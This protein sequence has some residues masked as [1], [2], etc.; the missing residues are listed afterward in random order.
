[1]KLYIL[2]DRRLDKCV[3]NAVIQ[4]LAR[5]SSLPDKSGIKHFMP[6]GVSKMCFD[7]TPEGS[8]I[9]RLIIDVYV[10]IGRKCWLTTSGEEHPEFLLELSRALLEKVTGDG[11]LISFQDWEVVPEHYFK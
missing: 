5:L 4:E 9:R 10:F 11:P 3:R 8:P 6:T 7:A 2:G 1:V